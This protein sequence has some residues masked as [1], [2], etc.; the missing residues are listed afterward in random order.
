M[1]ETITR[2]ASPRLPYI[3]LVL[4]IFTLALISYGAGE[5]IL[6]HLAE[7]EDTPT[8][9]VL[10]ALVLLAPCSFASFYAT[11]GTKNSSVTGHGEGYKSLPA[12]RLTPS[13]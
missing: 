3:W 8:A 6:H 2:V 12:P 1:Q 7:L 5:Q 13:S 9:P 11:R 10:A 4:A